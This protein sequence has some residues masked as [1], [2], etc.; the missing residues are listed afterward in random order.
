M[1]PDPT[2]KSGAAPEDLTEVA[3]VAPK[4]LAQDSYA[5]YRPRS[6]RPPANIQGSE[7]PRELSGDSGFFVTLSLPKIEEAAP[8][9]D[10]I[11]QSDVT[12]ASTVD[13]AAEF[14]LNR[15]IGRGGFGEVWEAEQVSLNRLVAVKRL[16]GDVE[17]RA[18]DST[19]GSEQLKASFRQEAFTA[20]NLEHPNIVPIHDLGID[21]DGR[22]VLA[23]KLVR[24]EPW[25]KLLIADF[26]RQTVDEF[27][28]N[29][30]AILISVGQAVAF[31]HSRGIVHRDLKPSQVMVGEFGEVLL[32]D[33]GL[34][35]AFDRESLP[36]IT[37]ALGCVINVENAQ[38]PAG[39]PAFM[40]P[41][42]T[43]ST[44]SRIGPWTDV[45]LLGGTLYYILTGT[46]PHQAATSAASFYR[47]VHGVIPPPRERAHERPVPAQLEKLAMTAMALEPANRTASAR[48]FVEELK[49]YL[50]GENKRRE[51]KALTTEVDGRVARA[52]GNYRELG[53]L[54]TMLDNARAMW[55][56]NPFVP[57][58]RER[59]LKQFANA[60]L[61]NNDLTLARV[62]AERLEN[63]IHRSEFEL[64]ID[65][66][67]KEIDAREK[68]RRVSMR[69]VGGLLIVL[70]LGGAF[71]LIQ[72][73]RANERLEA[74]VTRA[75]A[76][77]G[78][79]ESLISFMMEDLR[80]SLAP[81]GRLDVLNSVGAKALDYFDRLPAADRNAQTEAG[82]GRTLYHIGSVEVAQAR[83][84]EGFAR[85][86]EANT[87]ADT[88]LTANPKDIMGLVLRSSARRAIGIVERS[89]GDLD[90]ASESFKVA[91][92]AAKE[93]G[94]V[95]SPRR[96]W[97]MMWAEALAELG[98]VKEARGDVA[99]ALEVYLSFGPDLDLVFNENPD[100]ELVRELASTRA[101][102]VGA[103]HQSLGQT[104]N[105][106]KVFLEL[107][108]FRMKGVAENPKDTTQVRSLAILQNIVGRM[109]EDAGN[110]EEAYKYYR[111]SRDTFQGLVAHDP[112]NTD[113][114]R[115][116]AVCHS[117]LGSMLQDDGDFDAAGIE[118]A[119]FERIFA[120][121][122]ELD[123]ENMAFRMNHAVSMSF[124]GGLGELRGDLK[125][126]LADFREMR[127][128]L[129][130][131]LL[132]DAT[133][134]RPMREL[135]IAHYRIG[136]ML[137]RMGDLQGAEAELL[138]ALEIR[139]NLRARNDKNPSW[140][141]DL[142]S[143]H[144]ALGQL[145]LVTNRRDQAIEEFNLSQ[146]AIAKFA[147]ADPENQV[148][149]VRM[150]W[151][152][153]HR[154]AAL[155]PLRRASEVQGDIE[156]SIE[157]LRGLLATRPE[158]EDVL[159]ELAECLTMRGDIARE[160]EY[161]QRARELW[162]EA[163][164]LLDTVPAESK[165]APPILEARAR[166]LIRFRRFDEADATLKEM[167]DR[168][169]WAPGMDMLTVELAEARRRSN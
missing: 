4:D 151:G 102:L 21:S 143:G 29:H 99:G 148:L 133:N 104:E 45:F 17:E 120:R 89:R 28:A 98:Q 97:V 168:L 115:N 80:G 61:A 91:A 64:T 1:N 145:Y 153:R 20:A 55:G 62:Q 167:K 140:A 74:Q 36:N 160:Q 94:T 15:V 46:A 41:E 85:F 127:D 147:E 34:A 130:G 68:Q 164:D 84:E 113:W 25:D 107:L 126:A 44:A 87:I 22:P 141:H 43:E 123:P 112:S 165:P 150:A 60:A 152:A 38:S 137:Q 139:K 18:A 73:R 48:E 135:G 32:M 157:A 10:T 58:L 72:Q 56:G 39:T 131:M 86:V 138:K 125:G 11:T 3:A 146:D 66:R 5:T 76:A 90:G 118:F 71:F 96:Q 77:R 109:E 156:A 105:A 108:D 75:L 65:T 54:L 19:I 155:L 88:L 114:A 82:R 161:E 159:A 50:S 79:A 162:L 95:G 40:A 6:S 70:A 8:N 23:M 7:P 136:R 30:L 166:V 121:L 128:I 14:K 16:R 154:A 24:G 31:A 63:P 93:A 124:L 158:A 111:A 27:L 149:A 169:Y 122:R 78:D 103:A 42:Q 116:L 83:A 144:F 117:T 9:P 49:G 100:D 35:V 13:G 132:T 67:Q 134:A 2:R 101:Y 33:W 12:E 47:A 142:S 110:R 59:V 52:G 37:Q 69:A 53:D 51:S 163:L 81:I 92:E 106:R 119:E 26:A 57:S 129:S